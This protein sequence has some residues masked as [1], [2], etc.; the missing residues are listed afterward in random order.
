VTI[1]SAEAPGE[2]NPPRLTRHPD[3]ITAVDAE[4]VRPGL[5]AVHIVERGGRAA[6]VDTG[7]APGAGRVLAALDVLGIPR[8]AVDYVFLTHVHLDHAGGAGAL[9]QALP[10]ARAVIHPRG[11]PH[12]IDPAKLVAG[13]VAVYGEARYRDLYG[14]LTPIPANRVLATNDGQRIA[15]ADRVFELVHT[16]GHAMHHHSIVDRESAS[17]F[18]GDTFGLSYR[19]FDTGRG[20]LVV[21]TTTPTQFDPDQLIGSIVKLLSYKPKALYLTHYSRVTEPE[22]LAG[23]LTTQIRDFVEIARR[24]AASPERGK[25]IYDDMRALW[26]RLVREHGCTLP[27]ERVDELLGPD[28]EL[29]TQGLIAWLERVR[30]TADG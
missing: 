28:L 23:Q 29:N 13:S 10:N 20:P 9:M 24:H 4:Y 1:E 27:E 5:A 3:G 6:L 15:L 11:A 25:L 17:I 21:P 14:E 30:L 2:A 12:M 16:P 26:L 19:E 18:T 7:T 22:R 8:E